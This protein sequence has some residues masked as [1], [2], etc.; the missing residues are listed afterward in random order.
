MSQ[1]E[2]DKLQEAFKKG[3][4][5]IPDGIIDFLLQNSPSAEVCYL[6]GEMCIL[7]LKEIF[8]TLIYASSIFVSIGLFNYKLIIILN[9]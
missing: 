8:F 9:I 1:K 7:L 2:V 5:S 3:S 4:S 6:K